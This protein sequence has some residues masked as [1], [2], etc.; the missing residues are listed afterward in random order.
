MYFI[1][2]SNSA[3]YVS[4]GEKYIR[5]KKTGEHCPF[6][7][8]CSIKKNYELVPDAEKCIYNPKNCKVEEKVL[9]VDK[10]IKEDKKVIVEKSI[11]NVE[12]QIEI[13]T[14]LP[15]EEKDNKNDTTEKD[16][17]LSGGLEETI[18]N[19]YIVGEKNDMQDSFLEEKEENRKDKKEVKDYDSNSKS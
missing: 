18:G 5:C 11:E 13:K 4:S 19:L 6:Q 3:T 16:K 7:K 9:V 2:C 15:T 14:E 8:Y 1:K 10:K 17:Y 12:K